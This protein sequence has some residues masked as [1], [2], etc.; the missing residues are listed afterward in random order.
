MNAEC[1]GLVCRDCGTKIAESEFSL[2]CPSCGAHARRICG[3]RLRTELCK[4]ACLRMMTDPIYTSGVPSCLSP[5]SP[6]LT[7]SALAKRKHPSCVPIAMAGKEE[8]PTFTSSS[9][10]SHAVSQGQG[11]GAVRA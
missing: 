10:R 9:N 3:G 4:D 1:I 2:T 7:G 8:S 6:L 11:N 5:T